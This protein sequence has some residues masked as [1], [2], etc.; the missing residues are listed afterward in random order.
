MVSELVQ[1]RY[2]E[3]RKAWDRLERVDKAWKFVIEACEINFSES[4]NRRF[5]NLYIQRQNEMNDAHKRLM[6]ALY[7]Q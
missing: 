1:K 4:L 2:D 5:C 7:N 3:N 6:D